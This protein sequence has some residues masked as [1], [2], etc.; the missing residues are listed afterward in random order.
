MND[1]NPPLPSAAVGT[2]AAGG[3]ETAK[4]TTCPAASTS[5]FV[6]AAAFSAWGRGSSWLCTKSMSRQKESSCSLRR[7]LQ[8]L[9][10]GRKPLAVLQD[11]SP[12]VVPP[13]RIDSS[14][15][16]HRF[17]R[18]LD[19]LLGYSEHIRM[20]FPAE[21]QIQYRRPGEGLLHVRAREVRIRL[22][23]SRTPGYGPEDRHRNEVLTLVLSA[24]F[25]DDLGDPT[26]PRRQ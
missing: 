19:G 15:P 12:H 4:S 17:G 6:S 25:Q 21:Q 3:D 24:F 23:C 1:H 11:D 22:G 18:Q 5:H 7:A 8:I 2:Q 13:G 20:V 9:A 10:S 16:E 14:L 26:E